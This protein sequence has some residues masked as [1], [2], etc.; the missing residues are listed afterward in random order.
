[1]RGYNMFR[2]PSF[3]KDTPTFEDAAKT[4]KFRG[5][6]DMLEGMESMN[7]LWTEHC[8]SPDAEDD[9]F[10]SNWSYEVNAYNVVFRGMSK[11]FGVA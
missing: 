9:D 7:R 6:G 10:F 4:M 8:A 11:L 3:Y 1:M 2:V 5:N